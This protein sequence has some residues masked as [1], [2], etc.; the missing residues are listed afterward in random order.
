MKATH[1]NLSLQDPNLV[2][3][4]SRR[5]KKKK[6]KKIRRNHKLDISLYDGMPN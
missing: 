2:E 5:S 4:G 3:A 1:E 6:E